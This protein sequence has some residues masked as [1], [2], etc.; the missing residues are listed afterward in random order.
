MISKDEVRVL[1][2]NNKDTEII[3]LY[4]KD[5]K[6]ITE[7]LATIVKEDAEWKFRRD[8]VKIIGKIGDKDALPLLEHILLKDHLTI[9]RKTAAK[10]MG[11]IGD[12]SAVKPL[13]TALDTSKDPSIIIDVA[14]AL[15]HLKATDAI[16]KIIKML[17]N[18]RDGEVREIGS[19]KAGEVLTKVLKTDKEDWVRGQA[20]EALGLIGNKS[21][22]PILIVALKN[23][24]GIGVSVRV[25]TAL[26]RLQDPQA[27]EPLIEFLRKGQNVETRRA[28]TY[29]L[30]EIGDKS[31]AEIFIELLENAEIFIELLEN[32]EDESV[33]YW[34]CLSL[35]FMKYKKAVNTVLK[36]LETDQSIRVRKTAALTIRQLSP[37]TK[38]AVTVLVTRSKEEQDEEVI[39]QIK[40]TLKKI[41][42]DNDFKSQKE[43]LKSLGIE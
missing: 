7:I 26:G 38:K 41:A 33:R 34:S 8:A 37:K 18:S 40:D 1:I 36:V 39:Q 17:E 20:A 11:S 4:E 6:N 43:F 28:I 35:G 3:D 32:D 25:A 12:A 23:D 5:K 10:A 31:S 2:L 29:A 13:I 22:V 9:M 14:C 27:I 24:T 19:E 21:A 16:D 42:K 30:G 15:G